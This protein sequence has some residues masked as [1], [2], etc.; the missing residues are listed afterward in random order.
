MAATGWA[1]LDINPLVIEFLQNHKLGKVTAAYIQTVLGPLR[2]D[3]LERWHAQL[4]GL[5][6]VNFHAGDS[7]FACVTATRRKKI[8]KPAEPSPQ[9]G[10]LA[11]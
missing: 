6:L 10:W 9:A 4:D 3:A 8:H 2:R 5:G 7:P 11:F 1:N